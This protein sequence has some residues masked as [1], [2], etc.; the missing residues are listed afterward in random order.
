MKP[1]NR[2]Q[3][4]RNTSRWIVAGGSPGNNS[5]TCLRRS[6]PSSANPHRQ[7]VPPCPGRRCCTRDERKQAHRLGPRPLALRRCVCVCPLP[8]QAEAACSQVTS[9]KLSALPHLLHG[10]RVWIRRTQLRLEGTLHPPPRPGGGLQMEWFVC[11]NL[12]LYF[13]E[14]KSASC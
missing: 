1:R 9:R 12:L 4:K 8:L 2:T 6:A 7:L 5:N 13:P 11:E 14:R 10:P 3:G